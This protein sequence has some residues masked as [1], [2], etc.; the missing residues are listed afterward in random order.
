M[1]GC[2]SGCKARVQERQPLALFSYCGSHASNL[3]MQHAVTSCQLIRDSL[4]WLNEV[5]SW[6][7]VVERKV[8]FRIFTLNLNKK[9]LP[10][11]QSMLFGIVFCSE[12]ASHNLIY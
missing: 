8:R 4:Q 3:V 11:P 7:N 5:Q 10:P 9:T 6:L 2:H 12:Q 1:S